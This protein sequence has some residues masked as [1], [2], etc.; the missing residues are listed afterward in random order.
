MAAAVLKPESEPLASWFQ[1]PQRCNRF[2]LLRLCP[3][4]ESTASSNP[5][6]VETF[7]ESWALFRLFNKQHGTVQLD[8]YV[9]CCLGWLSPDLRRS[10]RWHFSR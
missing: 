6:V 9:R 2:G 4:P 8:H 3:T 5:S 1:L 10:S 7:S